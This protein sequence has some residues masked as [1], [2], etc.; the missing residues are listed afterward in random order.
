MALLK[1]GWLWR[2]TSVL[3]RWRLNWCDLWI[4]GSLCFYKSDSRR[5]LEHRVNLKMT[6]VDVRCGLECGDQT[7]PENNPRENRITVLLRDGSVVNLCASSE[8]ESIAWK[9]TLL[10]T[11][12]SPVFTYNPYEDS[13]QAIPI[14]PSQTVYI[15]PGAGGSHQLVVQRDPFDEVMGTVAVGLLAGMAAGTAMR[16]FLWMP[17]FFC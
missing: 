11:R 5:E 2:Q 14:N 16:S 10:E 4:N 8:D 6:C 17:L 1:S 3:K 9:L 13:Y 15:T 12:R 7:P